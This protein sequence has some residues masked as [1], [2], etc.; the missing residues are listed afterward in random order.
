MRIRQQSL[1]WRKVDEE[2]V[3]LDLEASSYLRTNP[4]GAELWELLAEDRT[5]DELVAYLEATYDVDHDRAH[6]DVRAF[7][8]ALRA[9]GVLLE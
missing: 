3:V 9:Q 8:D 5:E 6:A 4:T 7:L 1:L 2:G